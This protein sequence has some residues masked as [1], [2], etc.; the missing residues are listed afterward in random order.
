MKVKAELSFAQALKDQPII[1]TL[2]KKFDVIVSIVEASFST[3]TG[4]A[5]L[6]L[7]GTPEDLQK[8]FTF[9]KDQGVTVD[10]LMDV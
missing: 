4:W 10:E 5:I 7:D 9:L 8:A 2:C 6:V 1:C 3:D